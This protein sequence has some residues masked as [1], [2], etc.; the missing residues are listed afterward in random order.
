VINQQMLQHIHVDT[1]DLVRGEGKWKNMQEVVRNAFRLGFETADQQ[2]DQISQLIKVAAEMRLQM[3]EKLSGSEISKLLESRELSGPKVATQ[4]DL[5]RLESKLQETRAD[6]ARMATTRYVDDS[7]RRK[8]DKSDALIAK[9]LPI[10]D[11]D[12]VS[13]LQAENAELRERLNRLEGTINKV[14]TEV[15]SCT[16]KEETHILRAQVDQAFAS[17]NKAVLEPQLEAE[18]AKR[19]TI[20]V[21]KHILILPW[22]PQFL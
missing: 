2:Q 3:A 20:Q 15:T 6:I 21:I 5:F 13:K 4:E 9:N 11:A 16:T 19:V 12:A 8:A 14:Q 22:Y 1:T 18:L 17:A 7:L 10:R